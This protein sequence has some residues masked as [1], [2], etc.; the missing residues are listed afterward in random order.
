VRNECAVSP[1]IIPTVLVGVM[2]LIL[3]GDDLNEV[4]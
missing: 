1:G 4:R 2:S 3:N